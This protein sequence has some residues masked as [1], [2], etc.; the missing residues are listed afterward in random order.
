[1]EILSSFCKDFLDF[2]EYNA[3]DNIAKDVKTLRNHEK[4]EATHVSNPE[5]LARFR[6]DMFDMSVQIK[7]QFPHHQ[8]WQPD[9]T[10]LVRIQKQVV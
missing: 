8:I 4:A 9:R 5:A 10:N 7:S 6:K 3:V 1:M 2:K